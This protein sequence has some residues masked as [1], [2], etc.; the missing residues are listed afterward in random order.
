MNLFWVGGRVFFAL[1][2]QKAVISD[3]NSELINLYIVMRDK[4]HELKKLMNQHQ[5]AHCETYYYQV[6]E[7]SYNTELEKQQDFYI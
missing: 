1:Q 7:N 4:P 2:P 5:C 6:R 3:I